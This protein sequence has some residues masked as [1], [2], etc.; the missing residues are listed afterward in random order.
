M[1]VKQE[2]KAIESAVVIKQEPTT[3]HKRQR[4]SGST[5]TGSLT[6]RPAGVITRRQ[7]GQGLQEQEQG[8]GQE[9]GQ[10]QD[11]DQDKGFDELLELSIIFDSQGK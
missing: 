6:K 9:Q 10:E 2:P 1:S 7:A 5:I 4:S 3:A 11:E 8:Q